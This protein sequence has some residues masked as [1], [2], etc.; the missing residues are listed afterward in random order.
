MVPAPRGLASDVSPPGSGQ[1]PSAWHQGPEGSPAVMCQ[2]PP[3]A[4]M[5]P[6]HYRGTEEEILITGLLVVAGEGGGSG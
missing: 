2:E 4:P 3:G 1:L 6:H 5:I